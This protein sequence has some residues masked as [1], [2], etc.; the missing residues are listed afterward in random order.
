[1]P[2]PPPQLPLHPPGLSARFYADKLKSETEEILQRLLY[3]FLD[4]FEDLLF[5]RLLLCVHS[6]K[7][8]LSVQRD[9][10]VHFDLL[11]VHATSFLL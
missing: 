1:M 10:G 2:P 9:S 3:F 11:K 6:E 4:W 5:T 8:V 7:C